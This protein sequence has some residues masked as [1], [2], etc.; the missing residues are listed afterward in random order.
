MSKPSAAE[1]R[2]W[3]L[4][5]G[6]GHGA[7]AEHFGITRDEAAR[8]FREGAKGKKDTPPPATVDAPP[9]LPA[10]D[11]PQLPATVPPTDPA[12]MDEEQL[13]TLQLGHLWTNFLGAGPR[14]V[15]AVSKQVQEVTA[16]LN[17]V[18]TAKREAA[19]GH[20]PTAERLRRLAEQAAT[21]PD[22]MLEVP[23][24]VYLMRKRLGLMDTRTGAR[25]DRL[26]FDE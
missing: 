8:M 16:R 9:P 25:I 20:L 19:S 7:A 24:R 18:R 5:E 4:A 1:V 23:V 12:Q 2:A 13:L 3:E 14:D 11:P 17:E 22:A 15:S 6:K 10:P 26:E 21:W